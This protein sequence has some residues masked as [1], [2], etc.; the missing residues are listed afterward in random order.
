[1]EGYWYS[2]KRRGFAELTVKTGIADEI[3]ETHCNLICLYREF[4]GCVGEKTRK[5]SGDNSCA[6]C[7]VWWGVNEVDASEKSKA[8]SPFLATKCR[9]PAKNNCISQNV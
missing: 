1:M 3:G 8:T 9:C 6:D 4:F 5:V 7:C 2:C